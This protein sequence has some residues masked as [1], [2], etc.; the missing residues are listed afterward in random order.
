MSHTQIAVGMFSILVAKSVPEISNAMIFVPVF[1]LV[2][3]T[4]D[5]PDVGGA[6]ACV[7]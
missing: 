6:A 1:A 2:S 7:A 5:D 3:L 4:A